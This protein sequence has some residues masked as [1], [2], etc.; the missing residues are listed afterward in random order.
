[1]HKQVLVTASLLVLAVA[2]GAVSASPARAG[3]GCGAINDD[4]GM[5]RTWHADSEREARTQALK[6]CATE[7]K[8]CHIINCR[9]NIDTQQQA[10][11]L[12]PPQGPVD[13]CFGSGPCKTDK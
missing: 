4:G 11:A 9:E 1:M 3:W 6:A 7:G 5:G 13:H 12:W 8:S 10:H 2:A